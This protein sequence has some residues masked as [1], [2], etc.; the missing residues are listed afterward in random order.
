FQSGAGVFCSLID[1]SR[2]EVEFGLLESELSFIKPGSSVKVASF[3]DP[4]KW[5]SGVVSQINPL[6]DEK[7]Q[8]KVMAVVNNR[9]GRLLEGMN[10]RVIAETL[11]KGKLVVPKSSVVMRDNFDVLFRVSPVS[12]K[13]MWT[14][15]KVE[16]SNTEFHS[17]TGHKEKNSEINEGDI[18]IVS[19]NLNLAE[20]S[21]IEIKTR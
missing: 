19:G 20:G 14:Y 9:E 13:A 15:V 5:Y 4:D 17:V 10:V 7:G 11:I 2:F 21:N 8:I 12:G 6:V 1:D 3:S 16:M 18:I